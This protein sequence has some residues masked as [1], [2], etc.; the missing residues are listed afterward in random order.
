MT[1]TDDEIVS[2][3]GEVDPAQWTQ[4]FEAALA[5]ADLADWEQELVREADQ[6]V[7]WYVNTLYAKLQVNSRTKAVARAGELNL[8]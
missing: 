3:L 8:V 1:E 4:A 6:T 5:E 2:A 7:K